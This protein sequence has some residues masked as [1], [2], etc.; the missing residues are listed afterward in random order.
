MAKRSYAL[1]YSDNK[2]INNIFVALL[3]GFMLIIPF[4]RGLFFRNDYIP[5]IIFISTVFTV[6]TLYRFRDREYKIL[7]TYMDISVLLIPAAYLISFLFAA[8]EKDALDMFLLYCSYFMLYKLASGLS[9]RNEK[10]KSIFIS[11]IIASTFMLA[12]TSMMD[13]AGIINVKGSLIGRRLNGLYQYANTTASVLGVGIILSIN[14]L[15]NEKNTVVTA[16]YQMVLTA[17]ISPFIFTL[18]RGGYLVLAGVLLLNFILVRAKAK[19]KLMLGIFL[20]MLT[21]SILIYKY[22]TLPKEQLSAVWIPYLISIIASAVIIY[23]IYFIINRMNFKLSDKAINI[24]LIAMAIIFA[25]SAVFL[26]TVRE[27]EQFKI[28]HTALEQSS[29]KSTSIKSD[30][31][32]PNTQ[33][34]VS[35]DVMASAQTPNSYGIRVR[36]YNDADKYTEILQHFEATGPEFAEKNFDFTTPG[37]AVKI[38]IL[39]YNYE[40]NS[41][42]IYKDL[43]VKHSNNIVLKPK[44][45]LKYVP[46]AIEKRL[47][48]ISLGTETVSLRMYFAQDALKI[49][50]D[51]PIVGAG[52]GAWKNLYR[53]YQ[54]QPYSTT[55][56]HNFYMQYGTEVGIIGLAILAGLLVL[57]VVSMIK[58]IKAGS[59]ALHVYLAAML[60]LL[61][62]SIDFNLSLPAV[63]SILWMLVGMIDSEKHTSGLEKLPQRYVGIPVVIL[64][65]VV[66]LSSASI[67]Y[68]MKLGTQGAETAKNTKDFNKAIEIYERAAS[69]DRFN[70]AYSLDLAQLMTNRIIATKDPEYQKEFMKRISLVK[71]YEPYNHQYTRTICNMLLALGKFEEASMAAEEKLQDEPLLSPSYMLNIDVNYHIASYYVKNKKIEEAVPYLEKIADAKARFDK[72]NSNLSEPLVLNEDYPKKI[73]ASSRTL[74]MIK[75][76]LKK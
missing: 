52:G 21:S 43:L 41:Y 46:A 30:K 19:L 13:V 34:S 61:H 35:F 4:Y 67:Y 63:A 48:N 49:I 7:G 15:I 22:Y 62:S 1:S 24:A 26:F 2:T 16:I 76:D 23:A 58:S 56:V 44:G 5:A 8:N 42:T 68:G 75:A 14:K 10:Y 18:S 74:E 28:E 51:H 47:T 38:E 39:L 59:E 3:A 20:S 72:V 66:L 60:L 71:K 27:P 36:S 69:L 65:I 40:S 31:I 17:L 29:W 73:E 9:M 57:L 53:Q 70:A 55:E 50:K 6:F 54:S 32:K 12:F 45:N 25:A 33:Y 37:D 11:V 64:S